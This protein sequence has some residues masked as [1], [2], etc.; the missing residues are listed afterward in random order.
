M[1]AHQIQNMNLR[2]TEILEG[3]DHA[4]AGGSASEITDRIFDLR[5]K[6]KPPE[7]F[8][9]TTGEVWRRAANG[10]G[11]VVESIDGEGKAMW[12][13]LE[14]LLDETDRIRVSME[15]LL[16]GFTMEELPELAE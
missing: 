14:S 10:I 2:Y 13:I 16:R 15:S 4:L 7:P 9:V 12:I 11:Y 5:N 3:I 1:S 8:T 6:I